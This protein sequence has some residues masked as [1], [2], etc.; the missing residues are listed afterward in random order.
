M[1][2]SAAVT[3]LRTAPP[4]SG[5]ASRTVTSQPASARRLAATRP[6]GPAPMTTA[7]GTAGT[8]RDV[9]VHGRGSPRRPALDARP[10]EDPHARPLVLRGR[11]RA[12]HR[13]HGAR[14]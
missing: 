9:A 1:N 7:S 14:G 13:P 11:P 10:R 12:P 8:V 2:P 4:G 3:P 5:C 6:L